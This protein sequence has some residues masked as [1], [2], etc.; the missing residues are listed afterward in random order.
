MGVHVGD[1]GTRIVL[2]TNVSLAT[3]TVKKILAFSPNRIKHE[4]LAAIESTTLVYELADGNVNEIG[5]WLLQTYVEMTDWSG[6]G[7]VVEMP[8]GA[9]L[10]DA[11]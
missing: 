6:Y 11:S 1:I 8:V 9:R 10:V 2:D 4:W 3:A 5:T 7:D